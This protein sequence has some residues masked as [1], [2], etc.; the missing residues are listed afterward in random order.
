MYNKSL[1]VNQFYRCQSSQ[2]ERLIN[3]YYLEIS[4]NFYLNTLKM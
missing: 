4:L 2:W 1:F 3:I